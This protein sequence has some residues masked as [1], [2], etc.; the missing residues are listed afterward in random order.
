MSDNDKEEK[1]LKNLPIPKIANDNA[2][3]QLQTDLNLNTE[4]GRKGFSKMRG[5]NLLSGMIFFLGIVLIFD[6]FWNNKQMLDKILEIFKI[7]IFTLSG[8]LFGKN[9][10]E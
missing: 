4:E 2:E 3:Y 8:Y 10:K 9:E 5:H 7:L 1:P 6:F